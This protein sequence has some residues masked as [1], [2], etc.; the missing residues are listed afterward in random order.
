MIKLLN[1][2][3]AEKYF[4]ESKYDLYEGIFCIYLIELRETT[5]NLWLLRALAEV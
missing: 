1:C 5:G 2:I 3:T 4:N